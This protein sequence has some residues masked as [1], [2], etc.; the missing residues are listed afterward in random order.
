MGSVGSD[1]ES[2][3]FDFDGKVG[4]S[5]QVKVSDGMGRTGRWLL[6]KRQENILKDINESRGES[7]KEDVQSLMNKVI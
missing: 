4:P 1:A 7:S 5:D 6:G 2:V 3:T